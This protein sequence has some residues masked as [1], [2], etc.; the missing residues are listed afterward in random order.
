MCQSFPL[1]MNEPQDTYNILQGHKL[2]TGNKL[3]KR[4]DRNKDFLDPVGLTTPLI[5]PFF[6]HRV[7]V[8]R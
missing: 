7:T 1:C 8:E 2:L 6:T 4:G 3:V 5:M